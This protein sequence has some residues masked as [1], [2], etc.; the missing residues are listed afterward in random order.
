MDILQG[1]LQ[2]QSGV[3]TG[4]TTDPHQ[5]QPG[6][7]IQITHAVASEVGTG[8]ASIVIDNENAPGI[9][10][11]TVNLPS[12]ATA[13]GLVPGISVAITGV[14]PVSVGGT[15]SS[16][17]R[18]GQQ[19][20]VVMSGPTGLAPGAL[21]TVNAGSGSTFNG[22]GILVVSVSTST[23][24]NT[25]D[26]FTYSQVDVDLAG[27]TGGTVSIN[28][29][30]PNTPTPEFFEIIG[31]PS[32]DSFQIAVNYP[33]SPSGGWTTGRVT[34]AWNGTFQVQAIFDPVTPGGTDYLGFT[35]QQYGPDA[36][37]AADST[38]TIIATPVGQ[39]AP[40]Q[41]Q[42]VVFFQDRQGGI[43]GISPP[44]DFVSN[45]SQYLSV[46]DLPIGP[47]GTAARG[48]AF[49][50][51][52]GAF[53]YYI[54]STP[55]VNGQIV[56]TPTLIN[57]NTTTA[58]IFDFSDTTL[59][60]QNSA[61]QSGAIS[62]QG[63]NLQN[64]IVL[65]GA[66]GFGAY[67]SRLMTW[68]QRSYIQPGGGGGGLLNMG[69]DGG[70]LANSPT[71]PLG[72]DT[73]ANVGGALANGHFGQIWNISVVPGGAKGKL[74]Q[75]I[76]QTA[77]GTPI[78]TG[79][80]LYRLRGWF[81][82]SAAAADLTFT[83]TISSAS[84][85]FTS[86]ATISGAL[87]PHGATGAF[88][89]AEF[90]AAMPDAIP[91]DLL[92]TISAASSAT[93]V[94][95]SVDDLFLPYAETPYFEDI[96]CAYSGNPTGFDGV[97]GILGPINDTH[98]VTNM[99]VRGS[100]LAM[101]TK[102]PGGRLHVTEDNGVTE[103]SGWT[104]NERDTNCGALSAFC[105]TLSQGDDSTGSGGEEWL[106][107]ASSSGMRIWGGGTVMKI[108]EEIQPNWS[109]LVT[110]NDTSRNFPGI[111]PAAVTSAASANCCLTTAA[112]PAGFAALITER[113]LVP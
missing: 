35:Y 44:V 39:A 87:M 49:T 69:F 6:Y 15:I 8:I 63:N 19:V 59:F 57:D 55:Q 56:G 27:P 3:V 93:T 73:S 81:K 46:A 43:T 11:V 96:Y 32:N 36:T 34:Y 110:A 58:A 26:T 1:S 33:D 111:N 101:L 23:A 16:I 10:L 24:G 21:L 41:R 53:F 106:A 86:T 80:T 65:D 64:Q 12:G 74:S 18:S 99:G 104:V 54:P 92:L 97:S 13:T 5:L 68:G 102:D 82:L 83:S 37:A 66:L 52:Q 61:A 79:S 4:Y 51:A 107:W 77:N 42:M 48:V 60:Q 112:I 94:I 72:W 7:Q 84:T 90:S 30:I 50:G 98:A 89:E 14:Q 100:I 47:P 40:G 105:L 22:A 9:A 20:T 31:I 103:P 75:S 38:G 67:A 88:L 25:G 28:W 95:L 76:Y 109:G 45:G 78:A 113:S 17:V 71:L 85:S 2:R 70:Y 91:S 108:S 29:P 62:V